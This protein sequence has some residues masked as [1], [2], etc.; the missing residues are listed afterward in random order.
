MAKLVLI[1]ASAPLAS[2]VNCRLQIPLPQWIVV[3]APLHES[4]PEQIALTLFA[5]AVSTIKS[6]HDEVPVQFRTKLASV[7]PVI[8]ALLHD[9][10][11]HS[12]VQSCCR[13]QTNKESMH[14]SI[15]SH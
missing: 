8:A 1:C 9:L 10:S 3:P 13:G 5:S 15:V 4:F 2:P 6:V 14:E 7:G 12:T 11:L